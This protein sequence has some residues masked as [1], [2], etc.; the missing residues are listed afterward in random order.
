[1][2]IKWGLI[3]DMAGTPI[4]AS[5]VRDDILRELTY[6]GRIF[7]AQEALSYG[8]ATRICD[9][10]RA[11]AFEVAREIA[12]KSPHAIRAAKRLLNNLSV[13]PG[14]ALLAE[15]VEQMRL[16]GGPISSRRSRQYRQARAALCGCLIVILRCALSARLEGSSRK[17]LCA[18]SF[19]A[20]QEDSQPQDDGF[21]KI[22]KQEDD[23]NILSFPRHH[24]RPPKT[25]PRRSRRSRGPHRRRIA[26]ARRRAGRQRLH[27]DAQRRR[28]HRGGLCRD[29]ARCLCGAGQLALQAGGGRLCAEGSGRGC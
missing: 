26:T 14:P 24:Q 11:A 20:R 2:E 25:R 18:S 8:L 19:E 21:S 1:M 12:G 16:M 6:T 17:Q 29:A 28:F 27:P 22:K 15:S 5:L 23:R 7:S 9:D 13:D 4:L 10:P 3:P